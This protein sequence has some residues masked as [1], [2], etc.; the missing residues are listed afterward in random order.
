MFSSKKIGELYY[1]GIGALLFSFWATLG[2]A[3][4]SASFGQLSVTDGL[5]QNSAISIAQDQEGFLWIA[6]QDGLNRYDGKEF[7]TYNK[8]FVDIT[9]G[10]KIRLGKVFVRANNEIWI[11]PISQNPERLHTH[12]DTF[13]IF[14]EVAQASCFFEDSK[15][16]FWLGT[17]NG[18][19]H[20]FSD[21]LQRFRLFR[22]FEE[23]PFMSITENREGQLVVVQSH[24]V[25]RLDTQN[26]VLKHYRFPD[27]TLYFSSALATDS[28]GVWIGTLN[29]GLFFI[30]SEERNAIR[31]HTQKNT[32]DPLLSQATILDLTQSA[33]GSLWVA[34]YGAG[35]IKIQPKTRKVDHFSFN[36]QNPRSLHYNDILCLFEDA[37]GVMWL[38]TDGAGLSFYDK[39]LDKF[40]YFHN[41]QVPENINI[42]V[43]RSI[44]VDRNKHL[45]IGTSGKGLTEYNPHTQSWATYKP[46]SEIP[47]KGPRIMSLHE[48]KRGHLW[49]GY[50]NGGLSLL[51]LETRA[52]QHFN[53]TSDP[54]LPAQTIWKIFRDRAGRIWLATRNAGLIQFDPEIGVVNQYTHVPND[55]S[56]IPS[57]NI[58]TLVEGQNG[59]LWIGT[60]HDGIARFTAEN[61]QFYSYKKEDGLI[62]SN[63]IKSMYWKDQILWVGTNGHGLS[64]IDL[65]HM[66]AHTFTSK[67][68]LA[69]DVIYGIL[70]DR[71]GQLWLSSNKGISRLNI[72]SADSMAYTITNFS[73]YSGEASEFNTGAYFKDEDGYLYFGSLEG[74]YWFLG[75]NIH[76][77]PNAP[78]TTL[79]EFQVFNES[80][81]YHDKLELNHK[82]NTITLELASLGFSAPH[83]NEYKYKLEPV[84]E[85]W[86]NAGN[87][88]RARYTNLNPG[89]YRF[90]AVS[91]NYDGIWA[92]E[93]LTF[94]FTIAPAWYQ[95]GFAYFLYFIIAIGLGIGLYR[96]LKWRWFLRLKLRLKERET[97]RLK[98]VNAF[99]SKVFTG[100][101]HEFRTP[102]TLIKGPVDHLLNRSSNPLFTAQLNRI[103][104]NTKRLLD[105]VDQLMEVSKIQAGQQVLSV[106]K[107]NLGLLLRITVAQYFHLAQEKDMRI[108]AEIPV[109]TEVW[110]DSNKLSQIM[111]NLLQN[112][113]KYGKKGS[114][115]Q[116]QSKL[117]KGRCHI[118]VENESILA[119]DTAETDELFK[120]YYQKD[121][122][123]SGHGIG[124]S[125]VKDYIDLCRGAIDIDVSREPLFV[126]ELEIPVQK[127]DFHPDE[128]QKR[129]E[130]DKPSPNTAIEKTPA[131]EEPPKVLIVE[132]NE[133]IRSYLCD[134]LNAHFQ[135]DTAKNGKEG[136]FNARKTIP[137]LIVS[138]IVMPEMT[139]LE[140]CRKLKSD[141]TTSHIP[142][143]LLSG[144]SG[145]KSQLKAIAA[146]ADDFFVK[147]ISPSSLILRIQKLIELRAQ[148][149]SR[150][151]QGRTISPK[152]LSLNSSDEDFL[153]KVQKIID[154]ELIRDSFTIQ[155]FSQ[156]LGMS[157][158]QLH[159][160][161]KAITGLSTSAFIRDQRLKMALQHLE[162]EEVTAS[163]IAYAVGFSSPSYF[164]KCFKETYDMTPSSYQKLQ[165]MKNSK[166]T[167]S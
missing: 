116:V 142:V 52:L 130:A 118:R 56:S 151:S 86:I 102:L 165:R 22:K 107:G 143:L 97:S 141:Q 69:N 96:F 36:K 30:P 71:I 14:P 85:D 156:L 7:T 103:K 64:R 37:A 75:E 80:I 125:L 61:D 12:T 91:S 76:L 59:V 132:D 150:Y 161:L 45:W 166:P 88:P 144:K 47:L 24:A 160:K 158:M 79:V 167:Q 51:N 81:K 25:F 164:T 32:G 6:T 120:T 5:S 10:N 66:K 62:P 154:K 55:P 33:S 44:L 20:Y 163:E 46:E 27:S 105:L 34:T 43:V 39:F 111:S 23:Q 117:S 67:E 31:W 74:V 149:R 115:I 11:L 42:D 123:Q 104:Q 124:M 127:Y 60:E 72:L 146:G 58:R 48:D 49:I 134:E 82:E 87:N 40:Q 145:E 19:L 9:Q 138:D 133:E 3:Q 84:D 108:S 147:P 65:N 38:G 4:E 35:A 70:P 159:R 21:S 148:L 155:K 101:S 135:I 121:D 57:N 152:D 139:G 131:L 28:L 63:H 100:I 136:V 83:K 26:D 112:A 18:E 94:N 126:I 122:K 2:M 53:S 29:R 109:M 99:K 89:T 113:I 106:Q 137:D 41:Q 93:P 98:E 73:N 68:G 13:E 119:Y 17:L 153:E 90:S 110:F 1:T 129:S 77:N 92:D 95:T 15:G 157:R 114:T 54:P 8:N 78:P 162:Q 140:L 128:I 50:Q 16:R